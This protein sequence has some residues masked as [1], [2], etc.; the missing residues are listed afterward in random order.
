MK[1][2]ANHETLSKKSLGEVCVK[3]DFVNKKFHLTYFVIQL[4]DLQ[5]VI[6]DLSIISYKCK[7]W[8]C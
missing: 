4:S 2:T 6:G 1:I 7:V 8:S 5:K 3:L